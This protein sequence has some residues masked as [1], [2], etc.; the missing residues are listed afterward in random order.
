MPSPALL[1]TL[2]RV[3]SELLHL[4]LSRLYSPRVQTRQRT[5]FASDN[6]NPSQSRSKALSLCLSRLPYLIPSSSSSTASP[7]MSHPPTDAN[8]NTNLQKPSNIPRPSHR[9]VS[10]STTRQSRLHISETGSP[11]LISTSAPRTSNSSSSI[12]VLPLPPTWLTHPLPFAQQQLTEDSHATLSPTSSLR[13]E[14][15]SSLGSLSPYP[16]PRRTSSRTEATRPLK[17]WETDPVTGTRSRTLPF[18]PI[19][20]VQGDAGRVLLGEENGV[21]GGTRLKVKGSVQTL[22]KRVSKTFLRWQG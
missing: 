12:P 8:A 1:R 4:F 11:I 2:P 6:N 18:G 21:Q 10:Q 19:L 16:I 14:G 15:T 13:V 3:F 20:R 9:P 22:T 17:H 5:N 7:T